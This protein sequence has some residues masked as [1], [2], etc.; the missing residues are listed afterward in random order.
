MRRRVVVT[1][2]GLVSPLGV[3]TDATWA[4]I[5]AGRSGIGPITSFDPSRHRWYRDADRDYKREYG[6]RE[7]Y[8]DIYRQAF[9]EGYERGY[10]EWGYRR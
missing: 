4:G 2:I 8:R 6:A 7:Q 10:R 3:G 1:G 9:R 5:V